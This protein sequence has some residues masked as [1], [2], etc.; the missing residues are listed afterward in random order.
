MGS[1]PRQQRLPYL[2]R[3]WLTVVNYWQGAGAGAKADDAGSRVTNGGDEHYHRPAKRRRFV[4]CSPDSGIGHEIDGFVL[5]E[6]PVE[7]QR[8]MRIDGLTITHK[9][10][11]HSRSNGSLGRSVAQPSKDITTIKARCKITI[12]TPGRKPGDLQ[13]LFCDSQICTISTLQKSPG[14]SRMAKVYLP[15]PFLVP[16]EK[17]FIERDDDAVFDLADNYALKVELESAGDLNWPPLT[18][19]DLAN[20]DEMPMAA[21]TSGAYSVLRHWTLRCE[22]SDILNPGRRSGSLR[23]RKGSG[24]STRTDFGTKIDLNWATALPEKDMIK[25]WQKDS[26]T[27]AV[28]L[29]Q[30]EEPMPLTNG[31]VNGQLINGRMPN[32]HVQVME[33]EVEEDTEGQLTPSRSLRMRGPTKSYNLKV[34]SAKAQGREPR[35]RSKNADPKRPETDRVVYN[36]PKEATPVREVVVDGFSCCICHAPHQSLIQLRAHLLSHSQYSFDI[37]PSAAKSGCQ[38]DISCVAENSGPFLRPKIYQL[39]KPTKAFDIEKYVDGDDSWAT[40]RLGPN[41]DDGSAVVTRKA[42]QT[43]AIATR[44]IQVSKHSPNF[45]FCFLDLKLTF[46]LGGIPEA[47]HSS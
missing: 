47:H 14:V 26:L 19:A 13:V 31:H 37:D 2:Q 35:K 28:D 16:V 40:S 29:E 27:P 45:L 4:E 10:E 6:D 21:S 18:L 39:G 25:G 11:S 24:P 7:P 17:I 43:K 5:H 9:D 15:Q 20:E 36:L 38:I 8:S 41:N 34:L 12:S 42:P 23:V 30:Q 46:F 32:G 3:N 22:F 44:S 33:D 1:V